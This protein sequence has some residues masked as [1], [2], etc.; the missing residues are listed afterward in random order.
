MP[1]S[2]SCHRQGAVFLC[3]TATSFNTTAVCAHDMSD[4]FLKHTIAQPDFGAFVMLTEQ[5]S[6]F[7]VLLPV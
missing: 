1:A 2:V 7:V 6:T 5:N 3:Y 4:S